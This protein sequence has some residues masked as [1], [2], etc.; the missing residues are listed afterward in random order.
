MLRYATKNKLEI[1]IIGDLNC[2]YLKATL[3]QTERLLEFVMV[4]ELEQ[5]IKEPTRVTSSTSTLLDVLI[6]ST[7]TLFKEAGVINIAL[8]DHYPIYAIMR[9]PESRPAK[10]RIIETRMWNDKKVNDF[11]T[12]L[13]QAPWSMIDGFDDVDDMCSAWES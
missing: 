9:G 4:N 5:M 11:I 10:H 3:S 7:P 1:I 12:D 2:D 13:K 6:T 8:S